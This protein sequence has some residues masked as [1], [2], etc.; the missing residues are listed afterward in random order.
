MVMLKSAREGEEEE[1]NEEKHGGKDV[2]KNV[3]KK[4][5][6]EEKWKNIIKGKCEC[7]KGTRRKKLIV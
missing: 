3:L 6:R 1:E 2:C 4:K 7:N 5:N